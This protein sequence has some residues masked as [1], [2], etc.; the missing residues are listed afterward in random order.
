MQGAEALIHESASTY[1]T[2]LPIP[3]GRCVDR[4]D[5]GIHKA[6]GEETILDTGLCRRGRWAGV[7]RGDTL[8]TR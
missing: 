4:V 6:E 5:V 8:G 3:G 2:S 1:R 7:E